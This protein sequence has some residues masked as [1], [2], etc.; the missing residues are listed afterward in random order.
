MFR[1]ILV[2]DD[3]AADCELVLHAIRRA[4][5]ANPVVRLRD[6]AQLL[7]WVHARGEFAVREAALPVAVFLD[8]RMPCV[9]GLKALRELREAEGYSTL[10]VVILTDSDSDED[11]RESYACGANSFVVKPTAQDD[12]CRDVERI[13]RYWAHINHAPDAAAARR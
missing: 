4:G 1:P 11:M 10:P 7:D 5:I 3:S 6:G 13:G 8:L 12:F 9:D 2:V